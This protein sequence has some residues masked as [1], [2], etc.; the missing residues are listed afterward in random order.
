VLS[1][2]IASTCLAVLFVLSFFAVCTGLR[3][4]LVAAAP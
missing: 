4:A 3:K 1:G 2:I